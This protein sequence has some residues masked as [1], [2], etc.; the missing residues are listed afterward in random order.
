MI[1]A[2][3]FAASSIRSTTIAENPFLV[4]AFAQLSRRVSQYFSDGFMFF[5]FWFQIRKRFGRCNVR[6]FRLK[7]QIEAG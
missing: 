4:S 7:K 2:A 1:S 3:A 6:D 5:V